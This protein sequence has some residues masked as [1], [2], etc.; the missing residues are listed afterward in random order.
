MTREYVHNVEVGVGVALYIYISK[1]TTFSF[2]GATF[3]YKAGV[4]LIYQ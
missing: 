1:V 4:V 3:S 2:A